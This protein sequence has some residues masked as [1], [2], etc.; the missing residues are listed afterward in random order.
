MVHYSV[1]LCVITPGYT[2]VLCCVFHTRVNNSVELCV[3]TPGYTTVLYCVFH[4]KVHYS[5]VLCVPHQGTLQCCAVCSTPECTTVLYCVFHT[6]VNY[7][8]VFCV[9]TTPG[10]TAVL[11]CVFHNRVHYIVMLCVPQPGT[12][13]RCVVCST[14]GYTTVAVKMLKSNSTPAELGDLLSEYDLLKDVSHPNVVKLLGACTSKGGPIYL[15]IEYCRYGAL[16]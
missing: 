12:L 9:V 3:T 2:T 15:I 13:Q 5:V 1:V 14:P 10:Y 8:V 16:R 6:R 4:K 11:C 7:S